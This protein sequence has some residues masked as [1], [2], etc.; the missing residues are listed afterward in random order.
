MLIL[1]SA[2]YKIQIAVANGY[3]LVKDGNAEID[4]KKDLFKP[5]VFVVFELVEVK[6]EKFVFIILKEVQ[7]LARR[8]FVKGVFDGQTKDLVLYGELGRPCHRD[9]FLDDATCCL[10]SLRTDPAQ[11]P[12]HTVIL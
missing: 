3:A 6:H 12:C 2:T 8:C 1:E 4:V 5:C 9:T 10:C 7:V 11:P